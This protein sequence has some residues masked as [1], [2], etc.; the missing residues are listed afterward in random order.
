VVLGFI[1]GRLE[2]A[3]KNNPVI[4]TPPWPVDQL[5][6]PGSFSVRVPVLTSF[7]DE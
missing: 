6:F 7:G 5:L 3:M 4:T 2:Q 1:R